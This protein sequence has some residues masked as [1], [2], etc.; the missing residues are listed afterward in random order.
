MGGLILGPPVV[1]ETGGALTMPDTDRTGSEDT[2]PD[3]P[4][5]GPS[6]LRFAY[7]AAS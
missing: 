5:T 4:D 2:R 3:S 1:G 6:G 7:H